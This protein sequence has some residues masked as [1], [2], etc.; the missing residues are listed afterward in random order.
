MSVQLSNGP[1]L[2]DFEFFFHRELDFKT[3]SVL[4]IKNPSERSVIYTFDNFS[5]GPLFSAGQVG[6]FWPL[7]AGG[8]REHVF[9][10][11]LANANVPGAPTTRGV[12]LRRVLFGFGLSMVYEPT[13]E[14]AEQV[15]PHGENNAYDGIKSYPELVTDPDGQELYIGAVNIPPGVSADFTIKYSVE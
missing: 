8:H 12:T 14:A 9:T 6:R 10:L 13:S 1:G 15:D 5:F 3:S 2:R 11:E 7:E 4:R